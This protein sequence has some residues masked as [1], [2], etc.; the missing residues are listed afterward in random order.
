L[1]NWRP[2]LWRSR[3]F[4]VVVVR[5]RR[6]VKRLARALVVVALRCRSGLV[7]ANWKVRSLVTKRTLG[8]EVV[9]RH[10]EAPSSSR[11]LNTVS[12]KMVRYSEYD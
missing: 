5:T 9:D 7:D 4:V 2:L 12:R 8:G 10:D 6:R 3:E 1:L 11:S